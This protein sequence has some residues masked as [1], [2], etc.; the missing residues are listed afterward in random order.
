[1]SISVFAADT[2]SLSASHETGAAGTDVV[3]SLNISAASGLGAAGLFLQ[4][5]NTKLAYK[6]YTV[7]SAAVSSGGGNNMSQINPAYRTSGNHTTIIDSF[8]S[9]P[10]IAAGG[11]MLNITFTIKYGWTG[12][13]PLALTVGD[14]SDVSWNELAYTVANGSVTVPAP[15]VLITFNANGGTG[16]TSGTMSA[17][18]PLTAPTVTK[19]GYVFS[20]WSPS[21]PATVPAE[22]TTYTAQYTKT[23]V[24]LTKLTDGF[25]VNIQG[26]VTGYK[27]Q[28]WS[29]QKMTSDLFTNG[30]TSQW[31]LSKAYSQVSS[32][33]ATAE[34][35]GSISF[36]IAGFT[37][38]DSNYT[39]AVRIVDASNKFTGEIRDSYTPA[40]VQEVKITKLLADGE[41]AKGMV[42][43]EIDMSTPILFTVLGNNLPN[44][45]FTAKV[46]ETGEV[47]TSDT[48]EFSWNTGAMT[49]G[50]Y[51][52]VFTAG[53]GQT[54]DTKS[55]KVQLYALNTGIQY[56]SISSLGLPEIKD[57]VLPK[58]VA[59]TPS[60]TNGS[61]YYIISE[62]G[63]TPIYTSCLFWPTDNIEYT[64]K[65]FGTYLVQG[66]VN[67][68]F[69]VR[70]GGN[71]DDGYFKNLVISR[72]KTEPSSA[73]LVSNV[74]IE[75]PVTKGTPV[76]FTANAV[77][78]GIGTTPVQYSFWRYDAK[79]YAL[80]K[81]W[82]SDNTLEWT[83]ARV[84]TYTIE[85]RAKGIDAGSYEVAKSVGITV[86]DTV[87]QTAQGVVI[88]IN[89][90]ELNANAQARVPV[91]IK[92]SATSTNCED[93]FY[94]FYVSDAAMGA[95]QL[96]NYSI[97]QE[98]V[99]T[100]RKAGTY[101]ISVLV[102]NDASFGAYDEM[103]TF[104]IT[105]D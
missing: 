59:I 8:I 7:G 44:T 72:S 91:I 52:V 79:G 62:P 46:L 64:F 69:E 25:K 68:E 105:V 65:K 66:F 35:D 63:R 48:N 13:T 43:K 28:I 58:T 42:I 15:E 88:S 19:A 53:N 83:P 95:T 103:E 61:F 71:Y 38:P 84:G 54:S 6:S 96:Q 93:L 40:E 10:G 14:F 36:E 102:K 100:P 33:D 17:G 2:V 4:Y 99:W 70:I 55:V 86:T 31:I 89:E 12:S 87:D 78:G 98:C 81:D 56:G 104:T 67:R 24:S 21:L 85:V 75:N 73:T 41:Y 22:N 20:G 60:F 92:A 23:A 77:I 9:D 1:M 57:T 74:S 82:S 30:S 3:V 11:A 45:A 39:V 29:L 34:T 27:Y 97:S 101:T 90:A 5:D 32:P 37:S 80:V 47:I 51:T 26:W 16:G 76:T 49:P 18:S 94:K 50:I